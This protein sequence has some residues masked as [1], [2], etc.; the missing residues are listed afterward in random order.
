MSERFL[1]TVRQ[2]SCEWTCI[3]AAAAPSRAGPKL[4]KEGPGAVLWA[5]LDKVVDDYA[6]VRRGNSSATIEEVEATVL[7]QA[8]RSAARPSGSIRCAREAS[9][10]FRAVHPLLAPLRRDR[11]RRRPTR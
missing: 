5:I 11:T 1:I 2:G 7:R 6:P 8:A 4:L 10:F 9:D 3:A